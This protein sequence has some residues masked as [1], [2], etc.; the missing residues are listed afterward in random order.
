MRRLV[1][2]NQTTC[3]GEYLSAGAGAGAR[4]APRATPVAMRRAGSRTLVRDSDACVPVAMRRAGSRTLVRDSDACVPVAM[5]EAGCRTRKGGGVVQGVCV[6]GD[7]RALG[8]QGRRGGLMSCMQ[9][10]VSVNLSGRGCGRESSKVTAV[11][12]NVTENNVICGWLGGRLG[13]FA[14]AG[15]QRAELFLTLLA[16]NVAGGGGEQEPGRARGWGA[17]G[18]HVI[19]GADGGGGAGVAGVKEA[20]LP[21]ELAG[22]QTDEHL[23]RRVTPPPPHTHTHVRSRRTLAHRRL[24]GDKQ[25][26]T[27]RRTGTAT[28][29]CS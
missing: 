14:I 2:E 16:C 8:W 28:V 20:D 24:S 9:D 27:Q 21:E 25:H 22:L 29:T 26:T 11:T 1:E 23:R 19:L 18:A 17:G 13:G 6:R 5:K 7:P 3:G 10:C 15:V 4:S 12:S